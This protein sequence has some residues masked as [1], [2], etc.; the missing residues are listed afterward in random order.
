MNR[1]D[2]LVADELDAITKNPRISLSRNNPIAL[3]FGVGGFIGSSI[4]DQLLKKGIQVVGIDDF[5][6]GFR[7]NLIEASKNKRFHLIDQS[8]TDHLELGLPRL[9]Y[10]F[11]ACESSSDQPTLRSGL[12][13][14]LDICAK[15]SPKVAML[16]TLELYESKIPSELEDLKSAEVYMA[17]FVRHKKLN[18]RIIRLSGVYG[19]RMHFRENDPMLRLIKASLTGDLAKE[20]PVSTFLSRALYIDDAV[21]LILKSVFSGATSHKIYDGARLQPIQVTEIKQILLD[22]IWFEE[23]GLKI[24]P[25][26]AWTSPN[27]QKSVKELSWR[28]K[29]PLIDS[30]KETITYFKHGSIDLSKR[31][32]ER[33]KPV[34]NLLPFANPKWSFNNPQ[35]N[36]KSHDKG[37]L[38]NKQGSHHKFF[39]TKR[40]GLLICLTLIGYGL[41]W[42]VVSFAWAGV[43]VA[44]NL[45]QANQAIQKGDFNQAR[46]SVKSAQGSVDNLAGIIGSLSV[47]HR[48]GFLDSYLKIGER[49]V[50]ALQEGTSGA[51]HAVTGAQELASISQI[52]SGSQTGDL[53]S[54]Y[55]QAQ[56]EL[57]AADTNVN[58]AS[59]LV[60]DPTFLNQIPG[61]FKGQMADYA[62]KLITF[63][64][65]I[66][67]S[68][69][70]ANLLPDIT[71][72][73]SKKSYLLLLQN[74]LELRPTGGFIGSYGQLDFEN[75]KIKNIK[76][77]DIYN[78]DGNLKDHIEP[79]PE[80][81]SDLG[82]KDYFL[83]D[84][85]FD[86]DFPTTALTTESFYKK[87][88]GVSVD[89]VI[90]LDLTASSNLVDAVGGLNLPDYGENINKDNLFQKVIS[91]AEVGFFPGSQAKHNY[92]A[93]LE[94]ALFNKLFFLSNQNWPA[95]IGAVNQSFDQKH[96]LIYL[97]DTVDQSYLGAANWSGAFPKLSG[98]EVASQ[99][100]SVNDFLAVVDANLGANKANYY[101]QRSYFLDTSLGTDGKIF[102]KLKLTYQN[103]SPS[104]V[105]PAGAYKNR[106]RVYLPAGTKLTRAT[107]GERD[108]LPEVTSFSDYGRTGYSM[109]LS[110]APKESQVLILEYQ[111]NSTLGFGVDNQAQYQLT[112]QKEPGTFEDPFNWQL[113]YPINENIAKVEGGDTTMSKQEVDL[114]TNLVTDKTF[115]VSL[116]KQ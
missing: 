61:S 35:I 37:N 70:M 48:V 80:I 93:D 58:Q 110:V 63:S 77:D 49:G 22:P 26:P 9:D 104:D 8:I 33:T 65:L 14:F 62:T 99:S 111:L 6:L 40:L 38:E 36:E 51:S 74:N 116:E 24:T 88:A 29:T 43:S 30:L 57:N 10:G 18:G 2:L 3:I 52:I 41:I 13:Q 54:L 67:K 53:P 21:A 47:L 28:P 19:P 114:S 90:G 1:Y 91:H 83:R 45:N 68:R 82:Q 92:L 27:L 32:A 112:V 12:A 56:T 78:L 109:L 84:A 108:I 39:S 46:L 11:F 106:L 44:K 100:A 94:N 72:L 96:M 101:L 7:E 42:P 20:Q 31:L 16:S 115:K 107:V 76:V 73:G 55:S 59:V 102:H 15:F 98:G 81:K 97:N 60:N 17:N 66:D 50:L 75:G 86:P 25:L 87:E 23:K 95:I 5:S 89:G 85:N 105:F 4:A 34:N 113:T 79:P 71:G 103:S 64:N 69:L